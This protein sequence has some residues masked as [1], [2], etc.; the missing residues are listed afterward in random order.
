MEVSLELL[1]TE[2]TLNRTPLAQALRSTIKWVIVKLRSSCM[3][4]GMAV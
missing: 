3:A 1:G 2:K 4:K